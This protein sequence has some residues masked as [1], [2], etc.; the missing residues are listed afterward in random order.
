MDNTNSNRLVQEKE[1]MITTAI[2][3]SMITAAAK[4][5]AKF[6]DLDHGAEITVM[7]V[8]DG[9]LYVGGR[10]ER[11][12]RKL[13]N[14]VAVW[15]GTAWGGLGKGVDGKVYDICGY[16]GA[17]YV[18]G[19]FSY[20]N[21]GKTDEGIPAVRIGK[22]DGTK[23]SA[24]RAGAVVDREIYALATDGTNLYLGGNFTKINNET[25]TRSIAKYDGTKV[26]AMGG[27]FDRG[28][29]SM[30][31][32]KGKLYVGGIF[33][34]NGDDACSKAAVWDGKA[35]NELGGGKI[36]GTL[37]S[38]TNDG[39]SVYL[40]GDGSSLWKW[41]GS[42][43]SQAAKLDGSA[44]WVHAEG[45]KLYIAG[46]ELNG[47]NGKQTYHV[48]IL[49]GKNVQTLPEIMYS[50]HTV[51]VPFGGSNIIGGAYGDTRVA[52]LGGV[53]KWNGSPDLTKLETVSN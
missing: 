48:A 12:N 2:A 41:D 21:K 11:A 9:K 3:A 8:I 51:L 13:V 43:L 29:L 30:T 31:C 20:V 50:R 4:A 49:D 17:I 25:E 24:L 37:K 16:K 46:P 7:R 39:T 6:E 33:V 5:P 1:Q 19:D 27:Q 40:A 42:S 14:N 15:D 44:S 23:W 22:F 53:M 32:L 35:W 28:I 26:T 10:F 47:V 45:G 38:L 34:E 52:E 18:A 36:T